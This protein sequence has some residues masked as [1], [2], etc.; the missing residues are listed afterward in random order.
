VAGPSSRSAHTPPRKRENPFAGLL[1]SWANP[2]PRQHAV[3]YSPVAVSQTAARPLAPCAHVAVR[4]P[5]TRRLRRPESIGTGPEGACEYCKTRWRLHRTRH[6]ASTVVDRNGVCQS[7]G[8]F[9][10]WS[11]FEPSARRLVPLGP[12]TIIGSIFGPSPFSLTLLAACARRSTALDC[13]QTCRQAADGDGAGGREREERVGEG[14]REGDG[15]GVG[16][17]RK[18]NTGLRVRNRRRALV[19]CFLS[20]DVHS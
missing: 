10:L 19:C 14:K 11:S 12:S 5:S 13:I 16:E 4:W 15:E 8:N 9:T 20:P 1:C 3:A 2:P 17:G 18:S 6:A 7:M